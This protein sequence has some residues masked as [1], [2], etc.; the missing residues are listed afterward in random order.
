VGGSYEG[1]N[2]LVHSRIRRDLDR[3]GLVA[4]Q[5]LGHERREALARRVGWLVEFLHHHHVSEDEAIWPLA[6]RKQP[7]LGELLE[8]MESEHRAM[9]AAADNL[10]EA[11]TAYARDGSET[12]RQS[13]IDA[14][15]G[16]RAACLPHL[17]H[18]ESVAVPELVQVLDD[19]DWAQVD[20]RF[21]QGVRLKDLGWIAMWLLDDLEAGQAQFLRG[22]LPR[23][24]LRYLTWRWGRPY[25][26]E[27][28][29]AWGDL[30]GARDG[31]VRVS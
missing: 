22:Q 24:V 13:L 8:A 19:R 15:A 6:V 2:R 27:A 28:A 7:Q 5:P 9:A 18:E 17:E 20:K 10:R 30:A 21:R 23:P 4:Q 25:D 16:M 11:A 3:I 14:L 29:L 1:M 31:A 26:R 12:K